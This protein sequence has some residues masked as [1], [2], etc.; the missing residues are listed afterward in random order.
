MPVGGRAVV[1]S[2][3]RGQGETGR[4]HVTVPWAKAHWWKERAGWLGSCWKL[5]PLRGARLRG[6]W[7]SSGC[8]LR[9]RGLLQPQGPFYSL[10][11]RADLPVFEES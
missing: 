2:C 8:C 5:C 1:S 10:P 11:C 3:A 6:A 7:P 4:A 9:P